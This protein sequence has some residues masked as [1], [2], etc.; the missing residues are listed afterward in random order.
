MKFFNLS[1][2]K[3]TR[4]IQNEKGALKEKNISKARLQQAFHCLEHTALLS[5]WNLSLEE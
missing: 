3:D 5:P 2:K 4:E 1:L